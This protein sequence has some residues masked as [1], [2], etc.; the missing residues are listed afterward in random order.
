M[1]LLLHDYAWL[2]YNQ[3]HGPNGTVKAGGRSI[4]WAHLTTS[5]IPLTGG[6]DFRG[7]LC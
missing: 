4:C 3:A 2:H 1:Y 7:Y 5:A 6:E